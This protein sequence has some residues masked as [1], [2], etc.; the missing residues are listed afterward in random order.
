MNDRQ[1]A[2]RRGWLRAPPAEAYSAREDEGLASDVD[3][4]CELYLTY[5]EGLRSEIRTSFGVW[6]A[7]RGC[8]LDRAWSYARRLSET[9]EPRWL[10]LGLAAVSIDDNGTDFRDGY[11]VLGGLYVCA[12]RCGVEP[13]PYLEEA[14]ALSSAVPNIERLSMR[15]FLL[16]FEASAYFRESVAPKLG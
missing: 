8:M 9:C 15:D 7:V 10:R 16:G 1:A 3:L 11:V 14:A 13:G 6:T 12:V 2:Y 5:G 4:A